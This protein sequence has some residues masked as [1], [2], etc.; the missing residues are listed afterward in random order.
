MYTFLHIRYVTVCLKIIIIE[1]VMYLEGQGR[2]FWGGRK[3]ENDISKI[4]I[5]KTLKKRK[6]R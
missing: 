4:L 1:K 2:S 6:K 5:H 3:G